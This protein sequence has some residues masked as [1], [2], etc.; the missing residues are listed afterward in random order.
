MNSTEIIYPSVKPKIRSSAD[1]SPEE[2]LENPPEGWEEVF[3]DAE[4]EINFSLRKV[5]NYPEITPPL[6]K[7]FKMYQR[8][9]PSKIKVAIFVDE[10]DGFSFDQM[11]GYGISGSKYEKKSFV[12]RKI[13]DRLFETVENIEMPEH[14]SLER[15][16]S[17]GVFMSSIYLTTGRG[18]EKHKP[19]WNDFSLRVMKFLVKK[20]PKIIFFL[21]GNDA[22][23]Y[24]K[25][26]R[27]CHTF[28]SSFY[29]IK[30]DEKAW[31]KMNHFNSANKILQAQGISP[32]NWSL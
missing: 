8:I 30:D 6:S 1:K 26:I 5:K 17:Q 28:V 22:S 14:N 32:I 19:L 31:T 24:A 15:W 2:I 18:K 27:G 16:F 25:Y 9:H 21:W 23:E 4:E 11:Q 13:H 10:P 20:Y 7:I 3:K 12:M 29:S